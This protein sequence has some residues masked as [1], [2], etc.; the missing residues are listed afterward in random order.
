MRAEAVMNFLPAFVPQFDGYIA[1]A[2]MIFSSVC[3]LAFLPSVITGVLCARAMPH[4]NSFS[5]IML[6]IS[7]AVP[8]Y[9]LCMVLSATVIIFNVGDEALIATNVLVSAIVGATGSAATWR[10]CRTW[11]RRRQKRFS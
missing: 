5:A 11:N 10:I 9:A 2:F 1:A 4:L 6:G 7:V 8:A 3:L